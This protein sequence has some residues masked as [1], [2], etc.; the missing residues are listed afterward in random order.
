MDLVSQRLWHRPAIV[1]L[2]YLCLVAMAIPLLAWNGFV[3]QVNSAFSDILLRMRPSAREGAVKEVVLLAIDDGTLARYGP[4][5]L[6]RSTLA[7]GLK[8]LAA[9][10]PRILAVDLLLAEAAEQSED[11]RLAEALHLFQGK[12]I[13]AAA[14]ADDPA[15][16]ARWIPPLATFREGAVI[17]HVHA[18]PDSDG[19]VRSVLLA[20]SNGERR[21]WAFGLEAARMVWGFNRPL[22]TQRFL[23]VGDIRIPASSEAERA[24]IINY[25]GPE[26]TFTTVP[27]GAVVDGSAQR[28]IFRNKIVIL[29]VTAQGGGDHL[30]TPVSSGMGMSG[31]EIHANVA[32]TILDR[33]FLMPLDLLPQF[34][35][36]T[37]VAILCVLGIGRYR[38]WR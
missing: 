18:A 19:D 9:F 27:F 4:L 23:Q 12:L 35:L 33:A 25:A 22:E 1:R 31:I 20:K 30:F 29:G 28:E 5:P 6:K 14:M 36:Y 16:T 7:S 15:G 24:M 10:N 37:A 38:G 13:L 32:R 26:G 11:G 21:F 8:N 17:A 34:A 3:Q 2:A